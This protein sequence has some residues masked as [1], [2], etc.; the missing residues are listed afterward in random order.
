MERAIKLMVWL[1]DRVNA[2][3]AENEYGY[4]NEYFDQLIGAIEVFEML[5]GRKVTFEPDEHNGF[6]KLVFQEPCE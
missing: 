6:T 2:M 3:R 4:A 1:N 5:T